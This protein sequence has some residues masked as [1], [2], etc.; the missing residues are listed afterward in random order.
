M[1]KT[2]RFD[3]Q[4]AHLGAERHF[5]GYLVFIKVSELHAD[6]EPAIGGG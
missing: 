6:A 1:L 5:H 3:A 4:E 2:S